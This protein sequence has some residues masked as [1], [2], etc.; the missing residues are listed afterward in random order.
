MYEIVQAFKKASGKPIPYK[1]VQRR[2]GDVAESW[3]STEYAERV[4]GWKAQYNLNHMCE[5]TWRWQ[6]QNPNGYNSSLG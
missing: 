6:L 1:I 4:L 5:D 2:V 3:A